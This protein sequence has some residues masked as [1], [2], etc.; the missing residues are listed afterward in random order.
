MGKRRQEEWMDEDD[1]LDGERGQE[2]DLR[3]QLWRVDRG[4]MEP[5]QRDSKEED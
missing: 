4:L 3:R 1:L 2:Q 5:N